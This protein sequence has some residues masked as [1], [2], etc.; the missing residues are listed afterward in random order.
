VKRFILILL[1]LLVAALPLAW[2]QEVVYTNQ[3]TIAWDEVTTLEGGVPP[4]PDDIIEYK[5][6]FH[7]G[8]VET[9]VARTQATSYTITFP[10]EGTYKVGVQSVRTTFQGPEV[11]ARD[12]VYG[13]RYKITSL[14]DTDWVSIG[15]VTGEVGE[16]FEATGSGS[17]YGKAQESVV[18]HSVINWSTEN[19]A[20]TPDPFVVLYYHPAAVPQGL[21][22]D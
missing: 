9:F 22:V 6:Y 2:S 10:D 15:A 12:I 20:Q 7:S 8:G 3:I 19:G 4:L 13:T 16:I 11:S 14:G 1:V 17:G 18:V 5:V 21:R